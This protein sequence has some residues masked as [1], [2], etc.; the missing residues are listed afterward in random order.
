[1]PGLPPNNRLTQHGDD[2]RRARELDH[3]RVWP[4]WRKR[5]PFRNADLVTSPDSNRRTL[6]DQAERSVAAAAS[7]WCTSSMSN[8][9]TCPMRSASDLAGSAP[10]RE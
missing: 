8:A 5:V 7:C 3:S 6:M 9:C 1:M 2:P 4:L 10:G